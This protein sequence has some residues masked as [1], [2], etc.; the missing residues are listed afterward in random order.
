MKSILISFSIL[1]IVSCSSPP[2]HHDHPVVPS[3]D[4]LLRL[5]DEVL[6]LV[7]RK[8]NRRL[9]IIDSIKE[10]LHNNSSLTAHQ[11]QQLR[12]QVYLH[13]EKKEEYE[14]ELTEYQTKRK[15]R[16]DT[17][18]YHFVHD[19]IYHIHTIVDTI[20]KDTLIYDTLY[21]KKFGKRRKRR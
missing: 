15:I 17:I 7:V 10:Q 5:A 3:K 6:D 16:R 11:M 19:T 4:S 9:S 13:K 12:Q 21:V 18:I 2:V 8:D 1:F 20:R 14:T